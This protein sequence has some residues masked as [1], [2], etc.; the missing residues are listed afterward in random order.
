MVTI[1]IASYIS[2]W[3]VRLP[4]TPL[5]QSVETGIILCAAVLIQIGLVTVA[6]VYFSVRK[7]W[8]CAL[9]WAGLY[10]TLVLGFAIFIMVRKW[11]SLTV[12]M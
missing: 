11:I 6:A 12:N 8:I 3:A 5:R 1:A 9:A 2:V 7:V 4:V 10:T